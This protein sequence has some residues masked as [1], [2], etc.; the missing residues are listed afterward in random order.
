MK[1]LNE[2]YISFH[3]REAAES[4]RERIE[5]IESDPEYEIGSYTADMMHLYHHVNTAWNA[6]FSSEEESE[7]CSEENFER[8]RQYP[9]DLQMT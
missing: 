2:A 4:I 9:S 3:L 7:A 5:A 1:Q 8:W 6:R